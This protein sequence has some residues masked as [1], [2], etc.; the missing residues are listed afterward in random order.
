MNHHHHPSTTLWARTTESSNHQINCSDTFLLRNTH[1]QTTES[2]NHQINC[3]HTFLLR[4]THHQTTELPNYQI[5]QRLP[6]SPN[7]LADQHYTLSLPQY[8]MK[9]VAME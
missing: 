5:I 7:S 1:Y 3:S 2:P 4:Y 9:E 6:T 8:D